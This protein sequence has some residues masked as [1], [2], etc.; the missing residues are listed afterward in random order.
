VGSNALPWSTWINQEPSTAT[1]E[2]NAHISVGSPPAVIGARQ[3]KYFV[4]SALD[5]DPS[6]D[7]K[8]AVQAVFL[9]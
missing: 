1:S 6:G 2:V 8:S 3:L 5:G 4:I 9:F 7:A